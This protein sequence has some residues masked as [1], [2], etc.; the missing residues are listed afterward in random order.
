MTSEAMA[1]GGNRELRG[2]LG[3]E[4]L[5]LGD[6]AQGQ[7]AATASGASKKTPT[8][9]GAY[10]DPDGELQRLL[11]PGHE[12]VRVHREERASEA[13]STSASAAASATASAATSP[14]EE[15]SSGSSGS[16]GSSVLMVNG[17]PVGLEGEEGRRIRECLLRGVMPEQDLVNHLVRVR[18]TGRGM[19]SAIYF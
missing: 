12:V 3:L 9:P 18:E 2:G 19:G 11:G 15:A 6:G 4:G 7:P 13:V 10:L 14:G 5:S 16:S 17:R 1:Q 8:P